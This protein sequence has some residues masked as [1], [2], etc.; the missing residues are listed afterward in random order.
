M[1]LPPTTRTFIGARHAVI[2]PESHVKTSFPGWSGTRTIVTIS[3]HVG[4]G[5]VQYIAEMTAGGHAAPPPVGVERFVFVL[6]GH[7]TFHAGHDVHELHQEAFAFA[8]SG[9]FTGMDAVTTSRVFVLDRRAITAP[10]GTEPAFVVVARLDEIEKLPFL[11]DPRA[12]LQSLLPDLPGFDLAMNVFTFEPGACLP[13]V[14]S[15]YMEHG[16]IFLQ[17]GGIYR[18]EDQWYPVQREDQMWMG[19]F[20]PQWFAAVGNEPARYLYYKNGNRNP[21]YDLTI[22]PGDA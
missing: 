12:R 18:L 3:P 2:T 16:V 20:C 6:G 13:L 15:H 21:L 19:P 17:G 5:F 1:A 9:T 7:V 11:G 8:P 4:A 22:A 14:E 10:H